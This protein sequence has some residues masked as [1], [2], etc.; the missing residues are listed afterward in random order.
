MALQDEKDTICWKINTLLKDLEQITKTGKADLGAMAHT[1]HEIRSSAQKMEGG[2]RH[3]KKIMEDAGIEDDYQ[4]YNKVMTTPGTNGINLVSG[5]EEMRIDKAYRLEFIAKENGKVIYHH[6][7][8]AAGVVSITERV[9]DIDQFGAII[10]VT[11]KFVF[12]P[13]L[14]KWFAFNQLEHHMEGFKVEILTAVQE[15]ERLRKDPVLKKRVL[16][17]ANNRI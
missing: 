2:L 9:D 12:G 15:A 10:G 14:A 13:A 4:K 8:A 6:K 17:I 11:Q 1:L 16:D 7:G 3:R 5:R